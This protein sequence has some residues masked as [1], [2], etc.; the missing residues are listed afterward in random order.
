MDNEM[1]MMKENVQMPE[2]AS[3]NT[4][5][6]VLVRRRVK[7]SYS[8]AA[9]AMLISLGLSLVIILGYSTIRSAS[10]TAKL[11][12]ENPDLPQDQIM[13]K[14]MEATQQM[15]TLTI[16]MNLIPNSICIAI[17]LVICYKMLGAFK[18]TDTLGTKFRVKALPLGLLSVWA[19]QPVSIAFIS[20]MAAITGHTGMPE[21]LMSTLSTGD[22]P[23]TNVIVIVYI[24]LMA[25]IFEEFMFRGFV[26]NALS[27]VSKTFAVVTSA[28]LFSL[29]HGNFGQMPNAFA[30]GL[31]LGY[32]AVKSGS[33]IP[34]ILTH[35][36][37]N[38]T[39]ECMDLAGK[40]SDTALYI[41]LGT[42]FVI[43]LVCLIIYLKKNGKIDNENDG[44]IPG[45]KAPL[46][47]KSENT[48]KL[49]FK[50]P[51]FWIVVVYYLFNAVV[52]F[53]MSGV[54]EAAAGTIQ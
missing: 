1:D 53:A 12:A 29:F 37:L 42:E 19:V 35:I 49:L 31:I 17:A 34:C 3:A 52:L 39:A 30:V 33:I 44:V 51:T 20:L 14:V 4:P 48:V 6:P 24:C 18:F 47:S 36:V 9:T 5:D 27:P 11:M 50:C 26:L 8:T 16:F 41:F 45:Y 25:P 7:R 28:A 32:T 10:M 22:D 23:V 54:S 38:V 13:S 2:E 40:A 15:D 43:G 21:Q 46:P